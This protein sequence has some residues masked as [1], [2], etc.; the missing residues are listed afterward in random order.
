MP[1]KCA[2]SFQKA[3]MAMWVASLFSLQSR[4]G[5]WRA[6]SSETKHR[7]ASRVQAVEGIKCYGW[8]EARTKGWGRTFQRPRVVSSSFRPSA[9]KTSYRAIEAVSSIQFQCTMNYCALNDISADFD[10]LN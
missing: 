3:A 8:P 10:Q 4:R 5:G 6:G 1:A 2:K 9:E 7:A